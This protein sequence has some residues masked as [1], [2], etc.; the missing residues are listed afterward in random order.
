MEF[1]ELKKKKLDHPSPET[2]R[3]APARKRNRRDLKQYSLQGIQIGTEIAIEEKC[4]IIIDYVD[5]TIEFI[6]P[7]DNK[8]RKIFIRME[9]IKVST[10]EKKYHYFT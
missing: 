10:S 5:K 6:F 7:Y 3:D 8:E 2:P 4:N 1:V 9:D